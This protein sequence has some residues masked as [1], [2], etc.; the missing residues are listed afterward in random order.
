MNTEQAIEDIEDYRDEK[1]PFITNEVC[2]MA[3]A[4]L[5]NQQDIEPPEPCEYCK[6]MFREPDDSKIG[7]IIMPEK[8]WYTHDG[9]GGNH[10]RPYRYCPECGRKLRCD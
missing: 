1:M 4:A 9:D 6:A 2:N 7:D 8:F 10:Y 5:R 3:L